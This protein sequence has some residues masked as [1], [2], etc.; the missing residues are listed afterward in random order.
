[1]TNAGSYARDKLNLIQVL[2]GQESWEK[3]NEAKFYLEACSKLLSD[4]VVYRFFV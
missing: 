4:R 2:F 1:M 3:N